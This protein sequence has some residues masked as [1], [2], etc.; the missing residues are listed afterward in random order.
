MQE[1]VL[2]CLDEACPVPLIRAIQ[3]L[4]TMEVGQIL[5]LYTNHSC[6]I[7]NVL[8][9]AEKARHKVDYQEV[10]EGEWEIYIQKA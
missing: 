4:R 5:I 2:D 1:Q 10:G 6:S 9:W 7:K 3:E 8:E